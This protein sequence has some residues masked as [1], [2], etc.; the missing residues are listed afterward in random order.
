MT[1]ELLTFPDSSA[2]VTPLLAVDDLTRSMSFW[3]GQVGAAVEVEWETYALLRI[4]AGRLHLAV[5]GDPPP[6]R[7]IRLV[8]PSGGEQHANGEVVI[9]VSDC[10]AVVTA[11][12]ERG[13]TFPR[14]GGR[15]AVGWRGPGPRPGPGRPP[16][17]DHEPVVT[18]SRR[19]QEV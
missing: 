7:S 9:Q 13:V 4:G 1:E 16:P 5:T 11:L 3:V 19:S 2:T 8:P 15:T 14:T 12:L 17:G 6:D 18:A 10:H